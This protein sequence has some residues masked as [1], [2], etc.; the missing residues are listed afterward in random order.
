MMQCLSSLLD[1]ISTNQVYESLT[2]NCDVGFDSNTSM[3]EMLE[4]YTPTCDLFASD[5]EQ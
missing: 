1:N 4:I 3:K 2:L 5:D